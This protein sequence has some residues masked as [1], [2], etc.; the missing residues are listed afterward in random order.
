M[1]ETMQPFPKDFLE[2]VA[3]E[4]YL[5]EEQRAVFVSLYQNANRAPDDIANDL[6]ISP[7]AF[8][9]RLTGVYKAFE[10][11][12]KG[13]NKK[14]RLHSALL[15]IYRQRQ[16][17]DSDDPILDRGIDDFVER[18]RRQVKPDIVQRCGTMRVLD[19]A[20]PVEL[21]EIYTDVNILAKIS[22]TSRKGLAQIQEMV[23]LDLEN[24]E[25]FSFGE[26][27]KERVAGLEVVRKH[28]KLMIWGKPG[29]GK[30]TF[31][32]HLAMS[33]TQGELF[34]ELVPFFV[35]LK[36]FAEEE[37]QPNLF[38]YLQSQAV[39]HGVDSE[40][41]RQIVVGGRAMILLDGLD[42]VRQEDSQRVIQGL[43]KFADIWRDNFFA[44]TCRIAAKEYTFQGGFTEVEVA[45][46]NWEQISCFVNNWFRCK[47][48]EKK[49]DEFLSALKKQKTIQELASSPLLLTLLC[50][51]F[52]ENFQFPQNRAELYK[53]GL[54]ILLKK[55]DGKRAIQRDEIY[56]NLTVKRREQML[57]EIAFKTFEKGEYFF[58]QSRAESL[59]LEFIQ[60]LP[61][62]KDDPEALRLDSEMVL[63][64]IEA[65]HG[66][67]VERAKGIY[68]FS[69]L[70]FQEYLTAQ[71]LA[72][73]PKSHHLIQDNFGK[74]RWRDVILL[75]FGE[76]NDVDFTSYLAVTLKCLWDRKLVHD[77]D[78]QKFLQWLH[79]KGKSIG[80]SYSSQ[81][82]KSLSIN[83]KT[84]F[85]LN[86]P[87][88]IFRAF[89][90]F[91]SSSTFRSTYR[92]FEKH[93][94]LLDS[95]TF[96]FDLKLIYCLFLAQDITASMHFYLPI[97]SSQSITYSLFPNLYYFLSQIIE[98]TREK[99]SNYIKTITLLRNQL[100]FNEDLKQSASWWYQN[101]Y[102]WTQQLQEILVI[103]RNIG[104]DW[105]WTD[106]KKKTLTK[107]WYVNR[108]LLE[109]LQSAYIRRDVRE[110]IENT[111]FLPMSEIEKMPPPEI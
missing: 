93:S 78:C 2:Q 96:S 76:M 41:L 24:F 105:Q 81:V 15:E 37:D 53:D 101:G 91:L 27:A 69:H 40:R 66:L 52:E 87:E 44:I 46:F 43:Q 51:V 8:R 99:D 3:T 72:N 106:N 95:Y 83:I 64:A 77:E 45:D 10:I 16:G 63:K 7:N 111:M 11:D 32:K 14:R 21:G 108:F 30:T 97:S 18:V 28:R 36:N 1:I 49:V 62:A 19:M 55:W 90:L 38:T 34:P 84:D 31:L 71:Y 67:L 92:F 4:K 103:Y 23:G 48:E 35:T 82:L 107:Y 54:D 39:I 6:F 61:D 47:G 86:K 100:P 59:I 89:Y 20:Q 57:S 42:E 110:W 68:S 70:T 60:N 109:C 29:A 94:L 22:A 12:G 88:P 58:K 26:I 85:S 79:Q 75:V 98:K 5:T 13:S 73:K 102:S 74:K 17:R 50:L 25:R 65:Q 33:C 9:T 80:Q 56:K 104:H